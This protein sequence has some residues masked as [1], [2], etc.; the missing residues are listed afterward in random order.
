MGI[1]ENRANT[2]GLGKVDHFSTPA[3]RR[4]LP[5]QRKRFL[6]PSITIRARSR[7]IYHSFPSI[8]NGPARIS[9][10]RCGRLARNA[11]IGIARL[12]P[13]TNKCTMHEM[14]PPLKERKGPIREPGEIRRGPSMHAMGLSGWDPEGKLI[15]ANFRSVSC[16][17]FILKWRGHVWL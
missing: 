8:Q 6:S 13:K 1:N 7:A 16:R 11:S 4:S 12:K 17:L 2:R 10:P 9:G 3:G 14:V 5:P 15:N